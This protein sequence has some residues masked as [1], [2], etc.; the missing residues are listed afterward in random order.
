MKDGY[1][2][3]HTIYGDVC[4]DSY[5]GKSRKSYNVGLIYAEESEMQKL[6]DDLNKANRS[7]Y[8]KSEPEDEYDE[9]YCDED[10]YYFEKVKFLTP[11]MFRETDRLLKTGKNYIIRER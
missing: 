10:Y 11:E 2:I 7:F 1:K 3:V 9:D 6:V 4:G 5:Y 8:A